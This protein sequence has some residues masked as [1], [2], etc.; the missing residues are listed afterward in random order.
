MTEWRARVAAIAQQEF[1]DSLTTDGH[2]AHAEY[3]GER[4]AQALGVVIEPLLE[5]I[6]DSDALRERMAGLLT[7]VANALK[8]PPPDL[9]WHDWSDLPAVAERVAAAAAAAKPQEQ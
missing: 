4:I 3:L 9:T 7:G 1:E 8:G 5:D 2:V 6:E